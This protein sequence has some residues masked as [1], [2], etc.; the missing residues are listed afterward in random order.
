MRERHVGLYHPLSPTFL[1]SIAE[2][3]NIE[4]TAVTIQ[5]YVSPIRWWTC[6]QRCDITIPLL[7]FLYLRDTQSREVRRKV[8][9][10]KRLLTMGMREEDRKREQHFDDIHR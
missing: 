4:S 5:A 2:K 7:F 8:D 9:G 3:S 1:C 6:A 10:Y